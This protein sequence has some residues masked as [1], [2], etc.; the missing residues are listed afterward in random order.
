MPFKVK[1]HVELLKTA[2][3]AVLQT[4]WKYKSKKRS[5]EKRKLR[6]YTKETTVSHNNG[7]TEKETRIIESSEKKKNGCYR[8]TVRL[9]SKVQMEYCNTK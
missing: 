5:L 7:Q 4:Q 3:K 1:E 9:Q 2:E 6:K 8:S